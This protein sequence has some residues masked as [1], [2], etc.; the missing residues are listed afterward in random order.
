MRHI[1]VIPS[2]NM[3]E[4]L[5]FRDH[6][7]PAIPSVELYDQYGFKPTG[8]TNSALIYITN[9]VS[10]MLEDGKIVRCL[11]IFFIKLS[12]LSITLYS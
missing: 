8:S 9:T 7:S 1:S 12:T 6:I 11:L 5:V 10:I 3:V 2:L 4:R